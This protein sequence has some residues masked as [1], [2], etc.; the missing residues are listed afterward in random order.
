MTFVVSTRLGTLEGEAGAHGTVVFRGVPYATAPV[1][2]LRFRPPQPHEGWH[3]T[4][5]ARTFG[6]SAPQDR[7]LMQDI[8]ECS[9]DCLTLNVWTP[10][11]D[12]ARRPV[13]V[14]IHGGGFTVGAGSQ[15]MYEASMLARRGDV[16][17]VTINY[18]LGLLGFACLGDLLGGAHDTTANNG[19]RDQLAA[20]RWVRDNIEAFGGDPENVTIFGESAGGMSVGALLSSP[21]ARGLFRR[22]VAQSGAAHHTTFREDASR[23][24]ELALRGLGIQVSQPE[25]LWSASISE[26]VTAQRLC[27]RETILRGPSAKRLPQAS[28]TLLPV[29]GDDLLPTA[30]FDAIAAGVAAGIDVMAGANLDEWHYFVFLV[31]PGKRTLDEAGL[32]KVCSKRVPARAEEAIRLYRSVFGAELPA[33]KI[34]SAIETDRMFRIPAE[35]LVEAQSQHHARSYSYLFD[36]RSP[37]M[38]GEMGSCHALEVP[39][40]FGTVEGTF[41]RAFTGGGPAAEA[42]SFKMLDAWAAFAR[43]GDPSHE[44]IGTWHP[45]DTERRATMRFGAT[46]VLRGATLPELHAFW[47]PL[48]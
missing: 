9:E 47:Q 30:P 24:T 5:M 23:M 45:F 18:R 33:W 13:M 17:V 1:G 42:L 34:F 20:L 15:D 44:G 7:G 29:S 28:M 22:A 8:P 46:T 19:L 32:L 25:R 43:T 39:F 12:R 16:V 40:V 6:P 21:A 4:R 11:C 10:A 3:G 27:F 41:G 48:Q 14:W 35:R 2:A 37:L 38:D 26:I 36:W 31:E